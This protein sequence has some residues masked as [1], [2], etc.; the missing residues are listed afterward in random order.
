MS[1]ELEPAELG[2]KRERRLGIDVGRKET[3]SC[4]DHSL[5]K[6]PKCFGSAITTVTP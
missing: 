2:F 4:Q 5:K 1:V 3:D 6:S